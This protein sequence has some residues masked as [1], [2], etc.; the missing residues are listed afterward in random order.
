[1]SFLNPR[2][3]DIPF[4]CDIDELLYVG[5]T[6]TNLVKQVKRCLHEI[7]ESHNKIY[8]AYSGGMDS[9]FTLRVLSETKIDNI[10]PCYGVFN[11]NGVS[12]GCK[13]TDRAMRY[14][15]KLGYEPK[16]VPIEIDKKV[17]DEAWEITEKYDITCH[18][19]AIREVWRLRFDE[20]FIM[21]DSSF[22]DLSTWSGPHKEKDR[23]HIT[24]SNFLPL[25]N[26]TDVF[27][28][29]RDV[30]CSFISPFFLKRAKIDL[31]PFDDSVHYGY[32]F[33]PSGFDAK[34]WKW[35]LYLEAYPD[36]AEVFFKFPTMYNDESNRPYS[37]FINFQR[38]I[39]QE[40]SF[41]WFRVK[42][43]ELNENTFSDLIINEEIN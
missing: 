35:L 8:L 28:M 36:I 34:L 15:N 38:K 31:S 11:S 12:T 13:D 10:I 14:A 7:S 33:K 40:K 41:G 9:A 2:L 24:N 30:F 4:Y 18:V 6:A 26:A 37:E 19:T 1:M 25:E 3:G 29:D 22:C 16:V 21:S 5:G 17:I 39:N 20:H 32:P 43:T 27:G 42:G 23:F